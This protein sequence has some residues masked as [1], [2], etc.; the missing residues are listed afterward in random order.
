MLF[1]Y[2]HRSVPIPVITR[3]ASSTN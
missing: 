1:C 2:T 3:K